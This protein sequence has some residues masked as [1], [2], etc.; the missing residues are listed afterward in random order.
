[1]LAEMILP[2]FS[3]SWYQNTFRPYMFTFIQVSLPLRASSVC[4]SLL[5]VFLFLGSG[6][7]LHRPIHS[8]LCDGSVDLFCP[9]ISIR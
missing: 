6:H 4:L 3:A 9:T 7:P 5:T 2:R 8:L 1:M